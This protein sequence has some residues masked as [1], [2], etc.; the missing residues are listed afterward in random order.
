VLLNLRTET[1]AATVDDEEDEGGWGAEVYDG[2]AP[3]NPGVPPDWPGLDTKYLQAG[4]VWLE[5]AVTEERMSGETVAA[6]QDLLT[7]T[8]RTVPAAPRASYRERTRF[9]SKFD[10]WLFERIAPAVLRMGDD[11]RADGLWQ[12]IL[13]LGVRGEYWVKYYL[14]EWF[15]AASNPA[16]S[17]AEFVAHWGR[18]FRFVLDEADWE[19]RGVRWRDEEV[20][21]ELLGFG[22]GKTVFGGDAR[23]AEPI[24]RLSPEFE[25]AAGRWF[26][27]GRVARGL[28][29]FALKPAGAELLLPGVRWLAAAEPA[30]S[31]WAWE[32]DGIA[33]ALVGALRTVLDRNRSLVAANDTLRGAYFTPCNALVSRGHH[34][35]LALR[36]RVAAPDGHT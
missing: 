1:P 27:L 2:Y 13:A 28:C 5:T 11:R 16:V 6:L 23:H 15:R 25:Q 7:V 10:R 9:P 12:P 29:Y 32:H 17:P 18:M 35:A 20:V 8:L 19:V 33:D 21:G 30:W 36:E 24:G 26:A 3:L 4:F 34:A 14:S 31:E 22:M